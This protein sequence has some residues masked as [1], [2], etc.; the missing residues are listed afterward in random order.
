VEEEDL[1]RF[2]KDETKMV[3]TEIDI[4]IMIDGSGSMN[5]TPLNSA[6]QAA[7]I[8][9]E[10][11]SGKDMKMN[12]YV[13]MW[14]DSDP[15]MLIFPGADRIEIGKQMERAHKGLNSGTDLAPAIKKVAKTIGEQRGRAGT[16]SGFTHVLIISDGDMFDV[17]PAKEK[18]MT[19]FEYSDK[20]TFDVAIIGRQGTSMEQMA[21]NIKG[22]KT[23]Q[24]IG[25]TVGSNPNEV[26]SAIV[27]LLLEKV[28]KCGSFT[29]VPN[30]QKRRAMK[31]AHNKMDPK[32]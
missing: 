23:F 16:L 32:R 18:I 9:F 20:V 4:V 2:H 29:A 13:G 15:P 11:A 17:A 28:R 26:P 22:H 8:M 1:K 6:L 5:G 12:V 27:G 7:A 25:V 14:G 24:D 21:K 19:M 3:P 30:T 31:K 10:A